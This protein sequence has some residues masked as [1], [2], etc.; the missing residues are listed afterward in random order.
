M[1]MGKARWIVLLV[2]VLLPYAVRLSR[3]PGWLQQYT[4]VE[5]AGRVLLNVANAVA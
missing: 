3:G 2:G 5:C 1:T 4:H